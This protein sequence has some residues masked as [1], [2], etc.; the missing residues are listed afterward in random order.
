MA[1]TS[2]ANYHADLARVQQRLLHLAEAVDRAIISAQRALLT[3]DMIESQRV[4]TADLLIDR[5]RI[6]LEDEVHR[7]F[8]QQPSLLGADLRA[9]TSTLILA[10]ELERIGD[11]AKGIA[12]IIIRS[13]ALVPQEPP[14]SLSQMAYKAREMLQQAIRAVIKRDP[15]TLHRLRQTDQFVDSCYH[16]LRQSALVTL[17]VTPEHSEQ[18]TYL[19]WV[20]H[21]FERIA[22]RSVNIAERA[23]FIA[24]GTVP[25]AHAH[26]VAAGDL[27][28]AD[29]AGA[30]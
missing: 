6:E 28:S 18:A 29:V 26:P 17:R 7:L 8:A 30:P 1:M 22:D 12:V 21:N 20:A 27:S 23:A 14:P 4:V 24:T 15:T 3:H 10:T 11:Y 19:L 9:A 16:Q 2:R 25:A 5:L 13:A